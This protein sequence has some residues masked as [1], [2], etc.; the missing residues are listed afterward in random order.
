MFYCY[1]C[2]KSQLKFPIEFCV[3][4]SK[5]LLSLLHLSSIYGT[6]NMKNHEKYS[7]KR[8]Q[9]SSSFIYAILVMKFLIG[10]ITTLDFEA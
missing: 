10:S 4:K 6:T 2:S 3:I 7:S 8:D 1:V 9:L 5:V